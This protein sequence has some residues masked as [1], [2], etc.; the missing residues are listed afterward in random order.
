MIAEVMNAEIKI[1]NDKQRLR[2]KESE[3]ERL[4]ADNSKAKDLF[5]WEPKYGNRE[6]LSKGLRETAKWF[7]DSKNLDMYKSDI[8]NL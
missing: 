4:W 2:P 7:L 8:Y 5:G 1:I 6:G 3:V